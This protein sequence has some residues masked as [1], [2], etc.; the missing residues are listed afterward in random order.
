M[1]RTREV[2]GL[3]IHAAIQA[4]A[5]LSA[6]AAGL[7]LGHCG[8]CTESP[9]QINEHIATLP[10]EQSLA[11]SLAPMSAKL[12]ELCQSGK[13]RRLCGGDVDLKVHTP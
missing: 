1:H 6:D 2:R 8:S 7:H 12:I 10:Y 4:S 11:T 5:N 13:M 3:S 9:Q